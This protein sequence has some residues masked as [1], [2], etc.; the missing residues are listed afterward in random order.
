MFEYINIKLAKTKGSKKLRKLI[1]KLKNFLVKKTLVLLTLSFQQN[2][3][4]YL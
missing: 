4:D 2:H 1:R 3:Q